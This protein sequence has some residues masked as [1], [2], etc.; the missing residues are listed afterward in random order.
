M[1]AQTILNPI[2]SATFLQESESGATPCDLQDGPTTAQSGRDP[3]LAS[4]SPRQAKEKGL[5]TSGTCGLHSSTSSQSAI[6]QSSLESKLRAK[7]ASGGST[8]Y[9]LTWKQRVTPSGHPICA[10]R[11]SAPRTSGR[12]FTGW[13]TPTARDWKDRKSSPNVKISLN[14]L[15]GRVVWLTGWPTPTATD[16]SRGV[17][18]PRPW[19]KGIPLTQM[20][21]SLMGARLTATG[22]MLTGSC[23][24]MA[25]GGQLN[26][27]HSRWLMGLPGEWDACGAM[28]MPSSP[29]SRKL[30]SKRL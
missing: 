8:L 21:G 24:G 17:K 4:L 14:S 5:L 18:P 1:S 2:S 28:E 13:P 9:E 16:A 23:A 7:T 11:A 22:E 10:L 3:A 12:D 25:S 20:V 27:A 29:R 15:L 6:L 30:S 26:P 19:D